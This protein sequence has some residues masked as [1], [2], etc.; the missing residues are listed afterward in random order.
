MCGIVAYC[1]KAENVSSIITNLKSIDY[2][3]YDSYGVMYINDT[4]PVIQK[5]TNAIDPTLFKNVEST[6]ILAHTRWA[7]HGVVNRENSHPHISNDR[8][9]I[10]VHNGI[11]ENFEGLRVSLKEKKYVFHTHTDTEVLANMLQESYA[12]TLSIGS[13][14]QKAIDTVTGN[15]AVV[16]YHVLTQTLFAF[17][18]GASPLLYSLSKKS[19][20]IASDILALSNIPGYLY[21]MQPKSYLIYNQRLA[22][23]GDHVA[24]KKNLPADITQANTAKHAMLREIEIQQKLI[25]TTS[26]EIACNSILIATIS[27]SFKKTI[28]IGCGSAFHAGLLLESALRKIGT[29]VQCIYA[30]AILDY[31]QYLCKT[32]QV[33]ALSQSGETIDVIKAVQFA[34]L[35]GCTTT[36]ITNNT[37]SALAR[38]V[39]NTYPLLAGNEVAVASTKAFTQM[40][41][42]CSVVGHDVLTAYTKNQTRNIQ[43]EAKSV[44]KLIVSSKNIFLPIIAENLYYPIALECAL[45]LKESAYVH[46]EAFQALELKHGPL[47][48]IEEGL[49]C[50]SFIE[51][52]NHPTIAQIESRGGVVL[53]PIANIIEK[54]S[55]ENI[56]MLSILFLQYLAYY[57]AIAKNINPDR[58]RNL[59]KSVTVV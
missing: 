48:L 52:K 43:K 6:H 5:Y 35:Y 28:I 23:Y 14:I 53:C 49:M 39:D 30:H 50:I 47:A 36:A 40:V 25:Q 26:K 13:T 8:Q 54:N 2:R 55:K 17:V 45:K 29:D 38:L 7:T 31:E 10:I 12:K 4:V 51:D 1:G 18:T 9:F 46:A 3:G 56:L 27:S 15:N 34:K 41:Q 44:A 24:L 57:S 42:Y 20:F 32:T 21:T 11:L 37:N 19:L 16:G 33:I 22:T 59:A 58:P